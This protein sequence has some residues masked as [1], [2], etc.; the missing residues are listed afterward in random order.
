MVIAPPVLTMEAPGERFVGLY[1]FY[2]FQ[3][4]LGGTAT[5]RMCM[6]NSLDESRMREIGMM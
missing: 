5:Q 4:L 6:N 3:E 2:A 1:G